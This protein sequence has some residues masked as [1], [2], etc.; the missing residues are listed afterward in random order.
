MYS[1]PHLHFEVQKLQWCVNSYHQVEKIKD[2][3]KKKKHELRILEHEDA[4]LHSSLELQN[5]RG[6]QNLLKALN[7]IFKKG[8]S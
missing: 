8:K 4:E 2:L 6:S 7:K 3:Q 1:S 5:I